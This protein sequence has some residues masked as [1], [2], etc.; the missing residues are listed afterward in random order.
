MMP[1]RVGLL[2]VSSK[3]RTSRSISSS[4]LPSCCKAFSRD[5]TASLNLSFSLSTAFSEFSDAGAC[6]SDVACVSLSLE[7]S[8][9]RVERPAAASFVEVSMRSWPSSRSA[10]F[11]NSSI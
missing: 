4:V 7:T 5:V 3:A 1:L 8:D 10:C 9:G 6:T 2:N 11:L